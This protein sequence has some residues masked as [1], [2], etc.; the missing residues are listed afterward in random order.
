MFA[1][2]D[3][4]VEPGERVLLVGPSGSGKSTLLRAIA[5]LL[6]TIDSGELRGSVRIDGVAPR[7]RA[8]QVGLVLQEPGSGI[9]ASSMD[10][11][12][13]FGLE[14]TLVAREEM[15]HRVGAVLAEVG[16]GPPTFAGS[17][18]PL[19]LSGG[20]QQRLALAGALAMAPG[21]LLLDEPTAMLDPVAAESVR[22]AVGSAA[23]ARGLTV[24]VVEHLIGPWMPLVDRMIVL[25]LAGSMVADGPV[26][27][28]V[29]QQRD[30]LVAQGLWVPGVPPPPPLPIRLPSLD[31]A[32]GAG[33]LADP[34]A[35]DPLEV[36]YPV[37]TAEALTVRHDSRPLGGP[38]RITVAVEGFSD[39]VRPRELLVLQGPSGSGKTSILAALAGLVA[40]AA[41]T[42]RAGPPGPDDEPAQWPSSRLAAHTAWVPQWASST[43]AT[44]TVWD[45]LMLTSRAIGLD[46]ERAEQRAH[47]LLEAI[48]LAERRGVDPRLLSGGEQRRLA[49]AVGA[50]HGPSLYLADEPTV[51][52]DRHTWAAVTGVLAAMQSEGAALVVATHDGQLLP[53]ADRVHQV[54]RPREHADSGRTQPAQPGPPR[55]TRAGP[56]GLLLAAALPL[57][58]PAILDGVP[59]GLLVVALEVAALLIG[60]SAP[61]IGIT[62]AVARGVA[63]RAVPALLALVSVAWSTWLLGG[64]NL[65]LAAGA[66]LRVL[67]LLLPSVVLFT[68]IDPDRL[69]DQLA[70]RARLPAR[71]VV[72]AIVAMTHLHRLASLWSELI[73]A[74]RVRGIGAGRSLG[75]RSRE[76]IAVAFSLFVSAVGSAATLALA[77]DARGFA[78]VRRRTW[79]GAAQWA[80]ADTAVV[81]VSALVVAVGAVATIAFR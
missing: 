78:G 58:L 8:G 29:E 66:G 26:H 4:R 63:R 45:E 74:R 32:A 28:V 16:L 21:V 79:W 20:E 37:V 33:E 1:G 51:G 55:L 6:E 60:L 36:A 39:A 34:A 23:V 69:G 75:A 49:V 73:A 7:A 53:L 77:M 27:D 43:I 25:D 24:I 68:F 31:P 71:P 65:T 3:L 70:Q 42:V 2:L 64:R 59:A 11:D 56:L 9:V 57:V 72:A 15:P 62:A 19:T 50:V 5:G 80:A 38:A 47:V 40:P 35:A 17:S 61:G 18:S 81:A 67:A 76:A 14:N 22:R 44:R 54:R 52:Q 41:G 30:L 13:A 10:R 46:E 48:G 12:V